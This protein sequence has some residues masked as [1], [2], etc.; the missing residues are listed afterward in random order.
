AHAHFLEHGHDRAFGLVADLGGTFDL[1]I[2]LDLLKQRLQERL[3]SVKHLVNFTRHACFRG[4]SDLPGN[5]ATLVGVYPQLGHATVSHLDQILRILDGELA[6]PEGMIHPAAAELV[7]VHADTQIRDGDFF[8]HAKLPAPTTRPCS[9]LV[10]MDYYPLLQAFI[11]GV[12]EGLT[13]FL[14][15]SSTGHLILAGDLLNFNDDRGKLFEIVIQFG[16]I[17]AVVWEYR[18]RIAK[19]CG[20]ILND[21]S[22]QKFAL[23]LFV[24]FLPLAILGLIFGSAI[25][26]NLFA[27]V[28]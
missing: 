17:L 16:A 2:E 4:R 7:D 27:P 19:L 25:K 18:Q 6:A 3:C 13:E 14:P 20:G 23:N 15:I 21:A 28:P 8:Q 22:A 26:A 11:L 5:I 9:L 10:H 12:V 24:A 1:L